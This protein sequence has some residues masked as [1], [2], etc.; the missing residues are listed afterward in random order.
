ME[1]NAPGSPEVGKWTTREGTPGGPMGENRRTP[2]MRDILYTGMRHPST[3]SNEQR[4]HAELRRLCHQVSALSVLGDSPALAK[5]APQGD[6]ESSSNAN[7]LPE[8]IDF[9][10]SMS[11][12]LDAC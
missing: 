4:Y 10:L 2:T 9:L 5:R 7:D 12:G 6:D 8:L 11:D 3:L 1:G